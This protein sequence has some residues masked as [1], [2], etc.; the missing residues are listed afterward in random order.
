MDRT[1]DAKVIIAFASLIIAIL[2][3]AFATVWWASKMT[4]NLESI[5]LLMQTFGREFEKRDNA[6]ARIGEKLDNIRE[7]VIAVETLNR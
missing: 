4:A 2:S 1:M 3:H 7:R 5:T 6:I